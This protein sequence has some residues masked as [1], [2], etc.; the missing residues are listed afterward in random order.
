MSGIGEQVA[1]AALLLA[2]FGGCAR[3]SPAQPPAHQAPAPA[4]SEIEQPIPSDLREQ[5]ARSCTIGRALYVLDHVAAVGT[6]V[7]LANVPNPAKAGLA[8]YLPV[9]EGT[10]PGEPIQSFLV[11]FFTREDP[12]RIAYEV[13]VA[14]NRAPVFQAFAPAKAAEPGFSAMIRAR[15]LAIAAIPASNQPINPV[16]LPAALNGEAGTLVY[17]LAGTQRPGVA[18]FGRHFRALIAPGEQQVTYMMPLSKT[19]LEVPT[20]EQHGESVEALVVTQ[21]VTDFPLET[22]VFTSLLTKIPVYVGTRRGIWRVTGDRIAYLGTRDAP[23]QSA[24]AL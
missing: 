1:R 19:A 7:M 14:P 21:I 17:L 16:L 20:R 23:S 5:I 2:L 4:Q 6:D 15:Q 24:H 22:H 8:G 9:P 11:G 10:A 13:R 12:P 3:P 18:V